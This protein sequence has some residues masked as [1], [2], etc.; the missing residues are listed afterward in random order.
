M[1]IKAAV[2][3]ILCLAILSVAVGS[4]VTGASTTDTC[5]ILI[6]FGN[7]RTEWVD[8]P[9]TVGM[10]GYDV[11]QNATR[12]LGISET[13]NY[14][15]PYGNV[16]TSIDGYSGTYNFSDPQQ[17]Y[18]F[19]RLW[20][21]DDSSGAWTFSDYLLDG[22]D[23]AS[24]TA[25]AMIYVHNPYLGPP[26]ATP[27]YRDPWITGRGDFSNTGSAPGYQPTSA[28]MKWQADLKNGAIDA[29][30]VS[31]AGRLFALTSGDK[32]GDSYT[33]DSRLFCLNA[34]GEVQWSAS[35]G[36]GHQLAS[37]LLWNDTVFVASADGR[38][39]AFD[40]A[41]GRELWNYT[42]AA[43]G[44]S[45]SPVVH[46]NLVIV[47][48]DDGTIA[49]INQAGTKAWG[50]SLGAAVSSNP[51]LFEGIV[52][53]GGED[54]NLYA[55]SA[56]GSGTRW[57]TAVGGRLGSPVVLADEVI[58]TYSEYSGSDPIGGGVAAIS[59]SGSLVWKTA[60]A[61]TPGSA[62]VLDQGVVAA[63]S[64]GLS[65]ITIDGSLQWT[66]SYGTGAPD[67]SPVTVNGMAYLVTNESTSR[68]IAIS[69]A[70]TVAWSLGLE[71][72]DNVRASPSISDS[73]LYMGTSGGAVVACL[74]E[75]EGWDIPPVGV[76]TYTV[77]GTTAHFDASA[78][79][80]GNGTLSYQWNFG[81]GQTGDGVTVDHTFSVR[82]NHTIVLTVTDSGG[83]SSNLTKVIDLD[84]PS[85]QVDRG[86]GSGDG[87]PAAVGVGLV[88]AALICGAIIFINRRRR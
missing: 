81:D 82:G 83:A 18:D 50:V 57:S 87:I 69:A 62:A 7:G 16:I 20:V 59:S 36:R 68:V 2:P 76:F 72:G 56:D 49:A 80:G 25:I 60:T 37:P 31:A 43:G 78:S 88:A 61:Y 5:S 40:P 47:V 6:D 21:W 58:V 52:Y 19:W 9:V 24:T 51:A 32:S 65:L 79:Y 28:Q 44:I 71:T 38:L 23:A 29:S 46:N 17:P 48:S 77:D 54:G 39:F 66:T 26:V 8:V 33:S 41:T 84:D 75:G 53:V 30:I 15:A 3:A 12:T 67:G 73:M 86:L 13:H 34:A 1:I 35:V 4:G 14:E 70:G 10:T 74:L 85:A 22:I 11:F 42:V 27:E 55:V 64:E 45:T 63:S